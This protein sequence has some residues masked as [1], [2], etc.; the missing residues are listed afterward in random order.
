MPTRIAA[1]FLCALLAAGC[2]SS[3]LIPGVPTGENAPQLHD[4]GPDRGDVR[5][6]VR[7][8]IPR[9]SRKA[10]ARAHPWTI[11]AL[12]QSVSIAVNAAKA[13][14]F[15]VTP[16]SPGCTVGGAGRTCTFAVRAPAG[17]DNFTIATYSGVN[18]TGTPLDSGI[19]LAVPV[20][21]GKA[22]QIAMTLGPVVSTTANSGLGSLRYAIGSANSGDTVGFLLPAGSTI[23][24]SSTITIYNH[25]TIA[26]PGATKIAVSGG[27]A[28]QLFAVFGNVT[29]S[30]LTLTHGKAA[31]PGQPG[32][33]IYNAG[34][35]TLAR[36]V[37]GSSTSVVSA[38]RRVHRSL[39][40]LRALKLHP[41]CSTTYSE[42]GAVYNNG[43]LTIVGTTFSNNVVRSALASCID[44]EGGAI[45][46][47]VNGSLNSSGDTYSANSA[48][49]GGAVYNGSLAATSFTGDSF[50]ANTG[51]NASSGCPTNGCTATG[52]TSNASGSGAAI[53]DEGAGILVTNSKFTNNVA[54][55][56]TAGSVG[57]GGAINLDSPF[58]SITGSTFTGNLAGGGNSSCSSGGGGAIVTQNPI[59]LDNDVFANNEAIGDD[60]SEGGAV[61]ATLDVTGTNDRFTGNKSVS[62][63]GA[64]T[65]SGTA[66]G[67]AVYDE[68]ATATFTKSTFVGN[69]AT[70]NDV[71]G[72]GAVGG[73]DT[74]VL[75]GCTFT[76]NSVSA[77][78]EFGATG[79]T[80]AGGAFFSET[81]AKIA[82]S[83]FTSNTATIEGTSLTEA[84]GG[85]V[86]VDSGTLLSNNNT[87]KSNAATEKTGTQ[88]AGG[89][90]I[91]V[92]SGALVSSNDVVAS[93]SVVSSGAAEGGGI[94]AGAG[95]QISNTTITANK[96]SAPIA[97]GGGLV[98]LE[99]GAY[100]LTRVTI[101]SN[102]AAG[103]YGEGGG[104]YDAAG[105]QINGSSI[106][107]NTAGTLGG[108]IYYSNPSATPTPEA[109]VSTT[110]SGNT[111]TKANAAGAGG[112]GIFEDSAIDI[113]YSTIANN[114]VTT[115]GPGPAGGGGILNNGGLLLLY[116]TI[117]ANKVLGTTSGGDGG[118]GILSG[119]SILAIDVT[120][121]NNSSSMDG[122]GVMH[123]GSSSAGFGNATFWNNTA[124]SLG[125]N[126]DNTGQMILD[127]SAIGDGHAHSVASG[128]DVY[129]GSSATLTSNGYDIF[130]STF[131]GGG[132]YTPGTGDKFANPNLLTL[133]NNGGPTFTNADQT[134][135][136][137]RAYI[138]FAA[139]ECGGVAFT[140][141]DQRGFTRG[142]G[143]KCDVGAYEYA[144][145]ASATHPRP[146]P[147]HTFPARKPGAKARRIS[148]RR[149]ESLA[150][151]LGHRLLEHQQASV[152]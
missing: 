55:G 70:A 19:A 65:T 33:A 134:L 141:T 53:A 79:V 110:V 92:P 77:N 66:I 147:K 87:Y 51:C 125:G 80:A 13:Q 71:A 2:S 60:N 34:A 32:G 144:G 88:T 91:A 39:R 96:A 16:A 59:E 123:V 17:T 37:I 38:L 28:H 119:E 26:G 67:G 41:H 127:N 61:A 150:K 21:K 130:G 121:S 107:T 116:S 24:L 29:I 35:L 113:G 94:F 23:A 109:L 6:L 97:G 48:L 101:S 50:T 122:G 75:T 52:C 132:T 85:A 20:K 12:T 149:L 120:I 102:S 103:T 118:G 137:G 115:S 83:T 133:A 128:N 10:H 84:A 145:V 3:H 81:L 90:G 63:G 49:A 68:G 114:T 18:A 139:A 5:A 56:S 129:N 82:S 74:G 57:L 9:R 124:T 105:A 100:T 27:G 31:T 126:I 135:S 146:F 138:P 25:V 54:G 64:C 1:V 47:D 143:G 4:A 11:S 30:G 7:I 98:M 76:S 78:G 8:R 58:A 14:I 22:N 42:G 112:G 142:A 140:A 99:G 93:N 95:A 148:V 108:G 73:A 43:S 151:R 62:S 44:G 86:L 136:P 106:V 152:H 36:D 15:N 131:V 104:F 72:G 46:N 69:S 117:S 111:I 89:G 40:L 45:Y